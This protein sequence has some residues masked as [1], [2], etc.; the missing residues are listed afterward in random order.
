MINKPF[1]GNFEILKPFGYLGNIGGQKHIGIDWLLPIRT[2]VLAPFNGVVSF[3]DRFKLDGYGQSITFR[4]ESGEYEAFFAHLLYIN[5][6]SGDR[7]SQGSILGLSGRTGS[8]KIPHL[9]FGLKFKGRWKDP[10]QY[11]NSNNQ[12]KI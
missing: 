7:I 10:S 2:P 5:V 11:L 6:S 9:H 3:V 1:N 4:S 12:L 8:T